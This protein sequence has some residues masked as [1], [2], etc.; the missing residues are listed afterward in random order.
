[1][2]YFLT[3]SCQKKNAGLGGELGRDWES[4]RPQAKIF[5]RR[6]PERPKNVP[7]NRPGG[8]RLELL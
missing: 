5:R 6:P 7:A 2:T 8:Q 3:K 4:A 1:M